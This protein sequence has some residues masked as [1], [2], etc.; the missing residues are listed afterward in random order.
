MYKHL[1]IKL[2]YGLG[3]FIFLHIA[4]MFLT[5]VYGSNCYSIWVTGSY[6]CS[7]IEWILINSNSALRYFYGAFIG[8][9]FLTIAKE[10]GNDLF[11]SRI[12]EVGTESERITVRTADKN[13]IGIPNKVSYSTNVP[14]F[15]EASNHNALSGGT[16]TISTTVYR[17]GGKPGNQTFSTNSMWENKFPLHGC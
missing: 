15:S 6:M 7:T 16:P 8:T 13:E 5:Y 3:V 12:N 9:F 1:F 2:C 4:P 11:S 17:E 10:V 14:H